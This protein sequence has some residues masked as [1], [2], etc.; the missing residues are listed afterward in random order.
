MKGLNYFG[1]Y[2]LL[3][4]LFIS[5][6]C[7]QILITGRISLGGTIADLFMIVLTLLGAQGNLRSPVK[8]VCHPGRHAILL[9]TFST[10]LLSTGAHAERQSNEV[11]I[12]SCICAVPHAWEIHDHTLTAA[13]VTIL[14]AVIVIG[15]AVARRVINC[16]QQFPEIQADVPDIPAPVPALPIIPEVQG[17]DI[18]DVLAR[19]P[20][21]SR[22]NSPL[23]WL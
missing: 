12:Q 15:V 11:S 6:K 21:P 17:E 9:V 4:S 13:A 16:Q 1:S 19:A 22:L 2:N 5:I 8:S 10:S 7:S 20:I 18:D 14:A 3:L 23:S